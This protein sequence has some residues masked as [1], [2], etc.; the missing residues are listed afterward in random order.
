MYLLD[1]NILIYAHRADQL[2]HSKIKRRLEALVLSGEKW[3]T[4]SFVNA[5]F[6]RIVTNPK[7]P[8]SPT[9]LV[10]ALAVID[11]L[12][13]H[14]NYSPIE[15][16]PHHWKTLRSLCCETRAKSKR[17][18]DAQ[19]AAI[20]IDAGSTWVSADSDFKI[21]ESLGLRW[22]HWMVGAPQ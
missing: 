7:F 12:Y 10:Q 11:S 9:P 6:V 19:H 21:F 20:A 14:P 1:V 4:S 3:G 22:E 15:A 16:G 13:A 5:A 2:E 18:A 17:V 8:N